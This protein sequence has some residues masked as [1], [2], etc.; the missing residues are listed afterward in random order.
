VLL[1]P[2]TRTERLKPTRASLPGASYGLGL[3]MVGDLHY[4]GGEIFGWES[5]LMAN[6]KTGQVVVLDGNAC[7]AQG[8]YSLY[9]AL[10][11]FPDDPGTAPLLSAA[12]QYF[13]GR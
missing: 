8:A 13:S 3:E 7:G 6:P 1:S 10:Q 4:H 11:T 5:M 2:Q 9:M 12:E